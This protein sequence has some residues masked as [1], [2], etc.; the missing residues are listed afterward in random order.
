MDSYP[1][2]ILLTEN[3]FDLNEIL[4]KLTLPSTGAVVFFTGVVRGE[5]KRENRETIFLEYEAYKEMAEEKMGQIATEIYQKWPD[6]QGVAILQRIGKLLSGQ[7]TT[8]VACSA[9]H[10]DE[11]VFEAARYGIDRLKQIV[12]VWKK[13]IGPSGEEWVDGGYI[14]KEGE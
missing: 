10:R 5:S 3:E 4:H 9:A 2:I 14:P 7:P 13:E 8:L 1:T 12:P 6:I 11:H